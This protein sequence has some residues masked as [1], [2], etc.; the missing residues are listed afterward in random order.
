M[1]WTASFARKLCILSAVTAIGVSATVT[2]VRAASGDDVI[3]DI[4][5]KAFKGAGGKKPGGQAPA[6]GEKPKKP[7]LVEKAVGGNATPDELKSLLGYCQDL[8]K[9]KPPKGDQKDWDTRCAD[10]V[11]SVEAIQKGDK[12]ASAKLKS[13]ANCKA[14]HEL[15]KES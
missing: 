14:C 11:S 7:S 1:K 12:S 15:H 3:G 4:M 6:A 5:K 8:A 2:H 13:A 10:L 9:A